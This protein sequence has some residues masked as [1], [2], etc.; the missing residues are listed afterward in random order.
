MRRAR[1]SAHLH[2]Q[3]GRLT[4]TCISG[5]EREKIRSWVSEHADRIPLGGPQL[6][7]Q[8]CVITL[9]MHHNALNQAETLAGVAKEEGRTYMFGCIVNLKICRSPAGRMA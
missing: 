9:A 2:D 5:A 3:V 8:W 4:L 7:A 6:M 1:R